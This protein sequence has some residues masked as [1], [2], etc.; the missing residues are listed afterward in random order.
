MRIAHMRYLVL[1][2]R[3]PSSTR[4][5]TLRLM[6]PKNA[7]D[8]LPRANPGGPWTASTRHCEPASTPGT[9]GWNTIKVSNHETYRMDFRLDIRGNSHA[10]TN[11][12]PSE[13]VFIGRVHFI[14]QRFPCTDSTCSML[15]RILTTNGDIF[16]FFDGGVNDECSWDKA[17]LFQRSNDIYNNP[18]IPNFYCKIW[19]EATPFIAAAQ[20]SLEPCF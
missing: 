6:L 20:W 19:N 5:S 2:S 11:H 8:S 16:F 9:I 10:S 7:N 4:L 15:S 1:N 14:A 18:A 13:A 17:R 12:P 3:E